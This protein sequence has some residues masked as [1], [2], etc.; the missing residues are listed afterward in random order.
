M[1]VDKSKA[2]RPDERL[3]ELREQLEQVGNFFPWDVH[4]NKVRAA[5]IQHSRILRKIKLLVDSEEGQ[6]YFCY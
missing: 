1:R 3:Q 2:Q 6:E 4:P 5:N